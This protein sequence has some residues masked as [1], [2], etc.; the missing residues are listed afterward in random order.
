MEFDSGT[1][2]SQPEHQVSC[3]LN[4]EAVVLH[5]PDAVYFSM[6]QVGA[7]IWNQISKPVSVADI[8]MHV[9][10]AYD[11]TEAECATDV[12]AFLQE[13]NA[14]GLLRVI[15]ADAMTSASAASS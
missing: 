6:D 10:E 12:I 15:T 11:V 9:R 4:G 8:C 2:V 1:I 13:L 5:L 14:A 3:E 7:F